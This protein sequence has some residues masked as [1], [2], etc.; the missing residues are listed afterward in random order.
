MM[1][2]AQVAGGRPLL[3]GRFRAGRLVRSQGLPCDDLV[4]CGRR[5]RQCVQS[6]AGRDRVLTSAT[7]TSP[8][9]PLASASAMVSWSRSRIV[10]VDQ[11]PRQRP[12]VAYVRAGGRSWLLFRI[13][14]VV[15]LFP[16]G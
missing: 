8:V 5:L 14:I 9:V 2:Q 4:A 3:L 1:F 10:V 11:A 15:P 6:R 13:V 16:T 12:Q 7:A